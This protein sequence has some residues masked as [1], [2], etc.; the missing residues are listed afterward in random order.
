MKTL[1]YVCLFTALGLTAAQAETITGTVL[2]ISGAAV[3][4]A[5]IT[6]TN[7]DTKISQF[8]VAGPDGSFSFTGLVPAN[9]R[10]DIE[11][12]GFRMTRE[13]VPLAPGGTATLMPVVQL[14]RVMESLT[15]KS[16]GTPAYSGSVRV[17]VGGNVEPAKILKQPRIAY[18]EAAKAKGATGTVLLRAVILR[19]GVLGNP[20]VVSSPDPDLSAAALETIKR[21]QYV[22]T[23]LNGQPVETETLVK[24][25]FEL[26]Q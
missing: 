7:P 17:R 14:G 4:G 23:K 2:D 22:P 18:P 5:T 3:P 12:K 6:V 15:V 19:E 21:W 1:H 10:M 9:Y 11:A 25:T 24:V 16:K 20:T 26:E 13:Y 8:S